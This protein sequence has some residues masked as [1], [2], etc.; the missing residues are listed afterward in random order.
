MKRNVTVSLL[1]LFLLSICSVA[2]AQGSEASKDSIADKHH[3]IILIDRSAGMLYPQG[4]STSNSVVIGNKNRIRS[5]LNIIKGK[6]NEVMDDSSDRKLLELGDYISFAGFGLHYYGNNY[7]DNFENFVLIKDRYNQNQTGEEIPFGS[8]FIEKVVPGEN[9]N[10]FSD[11]NWSVL[12]SGGNFFNKYWGGISVSRPLAMSSL[13]HPNKSVGVGRTFL[14]LITDGE[15]NGFGD[16]VQ[17]VMSIKRSYENQ[18]RNLDV[19]YVLERINMVNENFTVK[20]VEGDS[21]IIHT[22]Q[23]IG[24][25]KYELSLFEY[26]PLQKFFSIESVFDFPSKVECKR[27]RGGYKAKIDF[28]S[29]GNKYYTPI[30]MQ[31]EL[32]SKKDS[33]LKNALLVKSFKNAPESFSK[34]FFIPNK[35]KSDADSL[36]L[37]FWLQF[38]DE[39]YGASILSPYGSDI[40]GAKGLNRMLPLEFEAK[41]KVYGLIPLSNNT[42]KFFSFGKDRSQ[43]SVRSTIEWFSF[44]IVILLLIAVL[45]IYI[46]ANRYVT[47]EDKDKDLVKEEKR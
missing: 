11:I 43:D 12:D 6:C 42:L 17:E 19:S 31:G 8:R 22:A 15:Y 36:N 24:G 14:F 26:I 25:G 46:K 44:V 3:I 1:M 45:I 47:D 35:Y 20:K 32:Y 41:A 4:G 23:K 38:N 5:L 29:M 33:T 21:P 9:D 34:E 39:A 37:K 40:Q 7:D 18:G 2:K 16:P 10:F 30:D 28:N 13:T 27:V